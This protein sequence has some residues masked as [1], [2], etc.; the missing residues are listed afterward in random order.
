[1]YCLSKS[2]S[3]SG[4]ALS[5][6]EVQCVKGIVEYLKQ[7]NKGHIVGRTGDVTLDVRIVKHTYEGCWKDSVR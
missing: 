4:E 3:A 5:D 1:M 7:H 6:L 2:T